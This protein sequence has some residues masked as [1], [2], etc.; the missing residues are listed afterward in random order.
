[1]AEDPNSAT[2]DFLYERP[3]K[4]DRRM[5][6]NDLYLHC[7]QSGSCSSTLSSVL[8]RYFVELY[9]GIITDQNG[10]TLG[11]FCCL[12]GHLKAANEGQLKTGQ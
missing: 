2:G 11:S 10:G 7:D 5:P 3:R 8:A 1:M 6:V 4:V 12:G 9:T